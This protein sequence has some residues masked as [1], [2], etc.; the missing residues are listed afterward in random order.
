MPVRASRF[1][2]L[3]AVLA[4]LVGGVACGAEPDIRT[5]ADFDDHPCALLPEDTMKAVVSPPYMDLAGVD[6]KPNGARASSTGDDTYACTYTYAAAGAPAVREV[7]TMTVTVAHSKSGSQPFSI[8]AAGSTARAGGYRTEQIGD[9]ACL[10]P[11]SDLWMRIGA[12]F[13][14]VVVVPQPGFSS[15]VEAN[16]ALSTLI[17]DVAR[18]AAARMPKA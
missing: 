4:T 18:A 15:P 3:A 12:D 17:L 16:Q 11:T 8:C 5:V 9:Q 14:H 7:A 6:V 1:A 10:S 2:L 13:Y